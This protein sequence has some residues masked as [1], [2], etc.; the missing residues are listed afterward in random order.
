MLATASPIPIQKI[1][2]SKPFVKKRRYPVY[3]ELV[4]SID[5]TRLRPKR[6][7]V[8]PY[9]FYQGKV[10]FGL[11]LDRRFHELT[12]FGGGIRYTKDRDAIVGALR[13]FTEESL[14]VFGPMFPE[15][16]QNAIVSY[17]QIMAIFFVYVNVNPVHSSLLFQERVSTLDTPEVSDLVW[18]SLDEFKQ[19]IVFGKTPNGTQIYS[20]VRR[21]LKE[22]KFLK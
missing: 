9:T 1:G 12:D 10:I 4:S 11:G 22:S 13:E 17:T 14:H 8:I 3:T 15:N 5:W 21:M 19:A 18:L 7:G 20:C 6:A 2:R 16:I